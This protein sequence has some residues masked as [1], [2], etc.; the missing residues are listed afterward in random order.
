MKHFGVIS[1]T[2]LKILLALSRDARLISFLNGG[3]G[4]SFVA[5][6]ENWITDTAVQEDFWNKS[7]RGPDT[8]TCVL[9]VR[10]RPN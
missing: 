2:F 3:Q 4:N 5:S 9:D 6:S 1:W 10:E 8:R 7:S